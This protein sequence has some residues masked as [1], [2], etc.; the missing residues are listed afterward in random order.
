MT[1]REK[2]GQKVMAGLPGTEVTDEFRALVRAHKIGNVILFRW[3]MAGKAQVKKLCADIQKLVTAETGYP[4]L[5][6]VDQEGGCVARLP[7]DCAN[8]PS[9]MA[10][11]AAGGPDL[12]EQAARLTAG[13][14]RALGINFDLAPVAD[15]N[16]DPHNPIIGAR[17]F[18]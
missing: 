1:I 9:Q 13:E 3:N 11:A 14:L 8:V 18:G 16:S 5:I 4:A 2:I 17:S 6:A 7:E 10:L 15:V 12:A